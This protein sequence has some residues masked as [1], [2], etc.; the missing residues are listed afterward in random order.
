M[1]AASLRLRDSQGMPVMPPLV[2]PYPVPGH[3]GYYYMPS[4]PVPPQEGPLAVH[5]A[6]PGVMWDP[7]ASTYISNPQP[8]MQASRP[9]GFLKAI[10]CA[11]LHITAT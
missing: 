9:L 1:C 8:P 4:A 3:P 11:W 10:A 2:Q 7:H 6:Q 5:S